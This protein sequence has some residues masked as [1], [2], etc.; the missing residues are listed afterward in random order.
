MDA[1]VAEHNQ[2]RGA[3]LA[4]KAYHAPEALTDDL[5]DFR[6]RAGLTADRDEALARAEQTLRGLQ[7]AQEAKRANS[8]GAP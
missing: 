2:I 6:E 1:L 4:N 7:Q 3:F 5:N 8:A